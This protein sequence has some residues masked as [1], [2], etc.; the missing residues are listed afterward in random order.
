MGVDEALTYVSS[1]GSVVLDGVSETAMLPRPCLL[2]LLGGEPIVHPEALERLVAEAA[3]YDMAIEVWTT[4]SWVGD[5]DETL[6]TLLHL[7]KGIQ[8]LRIHL[9]ARILEDVGL[10]RLERLLVAAEAARLPVWIRCAT[11]PRMPFPREI[12]ALESLNS[13]TSFIHT[14]PTNEPDDELGSAAAEFLLPTPS[15]MRCAAKF[16]F[17]V[18]PGG[19]A[20]PCLGGLG[21]DAL[22]VGNLK[23][24]PAAEI[25]A[26]IRDRTD[27]C[28]LHRAGPGSLFDRLAASQVASS[29]RHGY[30]D[31]CDFHRHALSTPELASQLGSTT[32]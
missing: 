15:R 5:Y 19:D 31:P 6:T 16:A 13:Q 11:G 23:L 17:F 27:L 2:S 12:L 18:T 14:F 22:R 21:L 24:Q 8:G 10:P 3:C 29:L 20:F 7:K 25:I 9:S 28:A 1:I 30:L 26:A 4:G 32:A